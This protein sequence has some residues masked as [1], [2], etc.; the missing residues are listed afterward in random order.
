MTLTLDLP[1]D[2]EERVKAEATRRGLSIAEAMIEL[3]GAC[4]V[5]RAATLC[6]FDVKHYRVISGLTTEQPYSR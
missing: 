1:P 5:G 4:A 3:V 2:L 6:T